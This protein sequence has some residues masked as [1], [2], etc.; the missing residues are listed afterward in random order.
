MAL[1][2]QPREP[3]HCQLKSQRHSPSGILGLEGD[4]QSKTCRCLWVVPSAFS[5]TVESEPGFHGEEG[6]VWL[7]HSRTTP[8]PFVLL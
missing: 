5:Q 6:L 3:Q 8:S 1:G 4:E 2:E 7:A